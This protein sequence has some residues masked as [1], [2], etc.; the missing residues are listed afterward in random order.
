MWAFLPADVGEAVCGG[1]TVTRSRRSRHP[2]LHRPP[3]HFCAD[4]PPPPL[5]PPTFP[6]YTSRMCRA[7]ELFD[8]HVTELV[9]LLG[10]DS[11][12]ARDFSTPSILNT[13]RNLGT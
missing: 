6:R 10:D 7:E 9:G 11:F 1:R 12:P 13:L 2:Q 4:S 3:C 8:P 5:P